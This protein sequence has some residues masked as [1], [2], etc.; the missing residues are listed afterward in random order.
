MNNKTVIQK[1][2]ASTGLSSIEV[3]DLVK[4]FSEAI[5]GETSKGNSVAVQGFGLFEVK[6]KAAR[7]IFNPTTKEYTDVPCRKTLSFKASNVLK[8]KL[9]DRS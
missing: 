1:I 9:N 6:E 2:A 8:E 3:A 4:A 5:V 7:R